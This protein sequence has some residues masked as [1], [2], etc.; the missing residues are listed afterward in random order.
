MNKLEECARAI[1]AVA[2]DEDYTGDYAFHNGLTTLDGIFNLEAFAS[3]VIRC[4]MEP[5][6]RMIEKGDEKHDLDDS[7]GPDADDFNK[8]NCVHVF[9]AMLQSVLDG[10][11]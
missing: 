1:H 8:R 9:R 7:F 4:L 3:A 6:D 5:T 11:E 10:K 2:R